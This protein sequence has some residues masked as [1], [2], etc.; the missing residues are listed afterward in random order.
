MLL[1]ERFDVIAEVYRGKETRIYRAV[2]RVD[3]ARVLIK[4]LADE[5]PSQ[6][7]LARF[8]REYALLRKLAGPGIPTALAVEAHGH[9][10]RIVFADEGLEALDRLPM[11][12][13][14]DSF[15]VCARA[16]IQILTRVHAAQ[17]LHKDVTPANVVMHPLR[18]HVQLIDFGLAAELPREV[19]VANRPALLEGTLKY[20]APE[21]TGRMNRGV[22][23]RA[24]YYGL[25]ATLFFAATGRPPFVGEDALDLVHS[26]I[27]REPPLACE[28]NPAVPRSLS[29]VLNK[30]LAKTPEERYQ[31]SA[32]LLSDLERCAADWARGVD[33]EFVLGSADHSEQFAVSQVLYGRQ[34]QVTRLLAAF[35]RATAGNTEVLLLPG[36]PGIGKSAL[37]SEV[38]RPM[39][40][41]RGLYAAGKFDQFNRGI[42]FAAVLQAFRTLLRQILTEEESVLRGYREALETV[43]GANIPVL[44]D[45]LPELILITGPRPAVPVLPPSETQHR[46]ERCVANLVH[47]LA[48]AAHPLVLVL[49]DLQWADVP[50][51]RLLVQICARSGHGYLLVIGA[52]RDG[53][54]GATHPLQIARRDLADR[55]IAVTE[56]PIGPLSAADV[57]ALVAATLRVPLTEAE[58]FSRVLWARTAGNPFF[59]TQYLQR[60]YR[61]GAIVFDAT[62]RHFCVSAQAMQHMPASDNVADLMSSGLTQLST[63]TQRVLRLAACI[64]SEFDLA[65]LTSVCGLSRTATAQALWPALV[66][67]LL[68]PLSGAYRTVAEEDSTVVRYRFAHDRIQ[69]AAYTL[70]REEER[71]PTHHAI[72]QRLHSQLSQAER[73]ERLFEIVT[74]MN[75]GAQERKDAAAREALADLN[76]Q[77]AQRAMAAAAFASAW[78]LLQTALVLRGA[79]RFAR[80]YQAALALSNAAAEGAAYAGDLAA[81]EALVTEVEREGRS[82]LDKARAREVMMRAYIAKERGPDALRLGRKHLHE[83]G[84]HI[85]EKLTPAVLLIELVR[86][87]RVLGRRTAEDLLQLPPMSDPVKQAAMRTYGLLTAYAYETQPLLTLPLGHRQMALTVRYGLSP[88]APVAI[89]GYASFLCGRQRDMDLGLRLSRA[90]IK[91][92][93]RAESAPFRCRVWIY[94]AWFCESWVR[95]CLES[96]DLALQ[97]W[98]MSLDAGDLETALTAA[99]MRVLY[100]LWGNRPLQTMLEE[101]RSMR[102]QWE[103]SAGQAWSPLAAVAEQ[104]V[105]NLQA[106]CPDVAHLRGE[107]MD[108]DALLSRPL[109]DRRIV[110]ILGL[111]RA[112]LLYIDNRLDE[113]QAALRSS[114]HIQKTVPL[115][116]FPTVWHTQRALVDAVQLPQMPLRKRWRTRRRIERSLRALRDLAPHNSGMCD[117]R[118]ALLQAEYAAGLGRDREAMD[119]FD[120]AIAAAHKSKLPGDQAVACERAACFYTARGRRSVAH[121]YLRD[122]CRAWSVWGA[123]G[124]VHT[125][126]QRVPE[127]LD[128]ATGVGVSVSVG[129]SNQGV[130]EKVLDQAFDASAVIQAAQAI[131][132]ETD[133]PSLL[134][135]IMGQALEHAGARRGT[136][137][138]QVAGEPRVQATIDVADGGALHRMDRALRDSSSAEDAWPAGLARFALRTHETVV[139]D[140]AQAADSAFAT[141][142]W[143]R[144]RRARSLL[145]LPLSRQGRV[146][147]VLLLDNSLTPA[148]FTAERLHAVR[149]IATQAA[150][151]LDNALLQRALSTSL[152]EQTALARA[153][154][155]FVPA[156]FLA[157]LDRPSITTVQLGD[158]VQKELTILFSDMREF[159]SHVEG[160]TPE[161]NIHFINDYLAA[162]EPAILHHGGF[163][164]S[165][166]GDA[167]MALFAVGADAALRASIDML[168]NLDAYNAARAARGLRPVRIGIGLN[169]GTVTLGTIGGPQRIKCG[170]IGDAVNLGARVESL[171]KSYGVSLILSHH[172]VCRLQ[173]PGAFLLRELDRVR[174]VGRQAAV[175]LYESF[176]AD[177]APLRE[178]K[179][180]AAAAWSAA[181]RAYHARDFAGALAHFDACGGLLRDDVTWAKRRARCEMYLQQ[182]PPADWSGVEEM[183]QK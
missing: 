37:I 180:S 119:A 58:E 141:D 47:V 50:S 53:E 1:E 140:D 54:V 85:P 63:D 159:T 169:T 114:R 16:L 48:T 90:T 149:V 116:W 104:V 49:D 78:E 70:L 144:A 139:L 129:Q 28:C 82:L 30:L 79:D 121:A 111:F 55:G 71:A 98:T 133:I 176:D 15:F 41:S 95:P 125:L 12:L 117:H 27:A 175:T 126:Q 107:F 29:A 4:C 65:T 74:H 32:G 52:Y 172:T 39:L 66:E 135:R 167:I 68:L 2:R 88:A 112:T 10:R 158:S 56:M 83:L 156:E 46:F 127:L 157:A 153:N 94:W 109:G 23:Y 60:L 11:P 183:H 163:V 64:G 154:Q 91:M 136:L 178:S 165:Y 151:A 77:A 75:K 128:A 38:Q 35:Q 81:M 143:V 21:Q 170:V 145:A 152:Q 61:E 102:Q 123:H 99:C 130:S 20:M 34:E 122:A 134:G 57:Q 9:A 168:R 164:D 181:L 67:G 43:L 100:S 8:E 25:G 138:L 131:A 45:V 150:I 182:P 3:G 137:I 179:Q 101:A 17:V 118:I 59:V 174:V 124:R 40:A 161:Q 96:S 103:R 87:N 26:H 89:G 5:Y 160:N 97:V 113:A 13:A 177:P 19:H 73:E 6:A 51:L 115:C 36:P 69:Q 24:D 110:P 22:D 106:P 31:S 155:R 147:G 166:I 108:Q 120:R 72:G 105:A 14:L 132:D 44:G 84:E 62:L 80:D 86:F 76:L 142:A 162:M 148:A 93:E 146:L 18:G 42:P 173:N 7:Q 171:S 92:A 33:E